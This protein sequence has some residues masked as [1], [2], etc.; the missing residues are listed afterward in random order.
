MRLDLDEDQQLMRDSFARF[1]DEQSSMARVRAT[2]PSGFDRQLWSGLA[3]LGAF[4]IRTPEEAGGMGLSTFDAAILMEEAGRTL[5]SGPIAETLL[6]ARLLAQLGGAAQAPLL[7]RVLAGQAVATLAFHDL[8]KAPRQWIAGGAVADVVIARR[9]DEVL[10]IALPPGERG[11]PNLAS[12]PLAELDLGSLGG[13]VIA[14][15]EAARQ[16]FLA[17]IEEWKLLIGAALFG[18]SRQAIQLAADYAGERKAFGQFIGTF[19]AIS[20]PL[21][22]LITDVDAGKYFLWKSIRDIAD[23]A[24]RA[25]A[26]ISLSTWWACDAAARS[27]SQA[28][29]TFGGY[30][31][32]LEYDVHLYN[33][34]AKAWP[35]AAGD[36]QRLLQEGARRL[37]MGEA[38][39]LPDVGAVSVDFDLG[40]DAHA[41]ARE[42]EAFFEQRMT[43][44]LKAKAHFSFDGHDAG[45]HRELAEAGLLMPDRPP[46]LNGRGAGPYATAASR[47]VWEDHSWSTHAVG[48]VDIVAHMIQRFGSDDLKAE[49][50]Q[51]LIRGEKICSLGYTEPG[52]GSDVFAGR[53]KATPD[54]NG[55][56]IDGQKMFTSGANISDYII[57]LARTDP[58]APKHKGIT[59]F[60]V[61]TKAPGVTVHAVH[62]WQDERTNVTYYDGVRIPD[63]YRLGEVNGGTKVMSAALEIEHA[64][65]YAKT[66]E[67]L[68]A[69]GEAMCRELSRE[70]RPLIE[71][72]TAQTRVA[73]VYVQAQLS[74][75]LM[76]RALWA[77]AEKKNVPAAGPMARVQSAE[78]FLECARDLLD[79]GAPDTLS[80]REGPLSYINQCYRH[81]H[82]TR[83]YG[84]TQE[85]HRSMIAERYLGLPRTRA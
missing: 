63:S 18:L 8:A 50:L 85:V 34:R 57:L 82:A 48:V 32:T 70:G 22:V 46:E 52:G 69:A 19:Q 60:I 16:A 83:I 40:E 26:Q 10:A 4:A 3:E 81:A 49:V 58:D 43:P 38:A 59:L 21:A 27:V 29:Q 76:D 56:R 13:E 79:L 77:A 12:T 11:E 64:G 44:E 25:G 37:Y 5:A 62:T 72:P 47:D 35:L 80:K 39:A 23:G 6:A 45:F 68:H 14:R 7:E 24:P 75:V 74:R 33:L 31:L 20:H 78:A 30:G 71:D 17:A 51:Q 28:M 41:L 42:T 65:G 67:R 53:T 9:G 54:G 36:P 66:M 15:G 73:K 55:W 2:L 84:G 61:P 1:L